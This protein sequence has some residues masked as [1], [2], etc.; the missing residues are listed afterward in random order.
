MI[1]AMN[2]PRRL[3]GLRIISLI[4][5]LLAGG[6][7]CKIRYNPFQFPPRLPFKID[8]AIREPQSEAPA[9]IMKPTSARPAIPSR[10]AIG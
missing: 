6:T 5:I 1:A 10:S 3:G 7:G 8:G 4:F 2:E 9:P